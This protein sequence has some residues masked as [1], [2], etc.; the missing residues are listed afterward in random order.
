MVL[1]YPF[2]RHCGSESHN[3]VKKIRHL[4]PRRRRYP[5]SKPGSACCMPGL[6]VS[7]FSLMS[8]CSW[9][10]RPPRNSCH[11]TRVTRSV[12][13]QAFACMNGPTRLRQH[14]IIYPFS[15]H[16]G[17]PSHNVVKKIGHLPPCWRRNFLPE[18][19]ASCRRDGRFPLYN[20][21][22][23][24]QQIMGFRI[25]GAGMDSDI[26]PA[27]FVKIRFGPEPSG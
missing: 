18:G 13:T 25:C 7:R 27:H 10:K 20:I 24:K 21:V 19:E 3:F 9:S 16:C 6:A 22:N 8:W 5:P 2:S 12:S 1:F 14:G 23:I 11:L 17:S 26:M 15:R 4:P